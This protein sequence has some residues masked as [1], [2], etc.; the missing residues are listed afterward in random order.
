MNEYPK[1]IFTIDVE[2]YYHIV[3]DRG[4]PPIS[5]WDSLPS[6]VE[7]GFLRLLDLLDVYEVKATCFFLGYIAKKY[8]YLV[9]EARKRGHEIASH[10]MFHKVIAH[11]SR[12]E[13]MADFHNSKSLLEDICSEEI[14][15]FRSP[16]FSVTEATPWFFESLAETGYIADSSVFPVKR[17]YGG[18]QIEQKKPYWIKTDKGNI[19]EFPISVAS[20]LGKEICFFGGGYLRFFPKWVILYMHKKLAKKGIPTLYYIHPREMEPQHPR[21][22]LNKTSYFKCYVNLK[23]VK[24]KLEAIL[25]SSEFVTCRQYLKEMKNS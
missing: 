14:T 24:P 19:C 12:E 21:L 15:T 3:S 22:N 13:L 2:D 20:L 6:I 23:T 9:K 17:D 4:V 1:S 16:S 18:Y 25:S 5:E 10:G 11:M 8:P 7:S